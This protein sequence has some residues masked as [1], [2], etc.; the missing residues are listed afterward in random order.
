MRP[1]PREARTQAGRRPARPS[2][3]ARISS[4]S[5]AN[6]GCAA[7]RRR[8]TR[9]GRRGRRRRCRAA[10]RRRRHAAARGQI[11]RAPLQE[12]AQR[13][14]RDQTAIEQRRDAGAQP[15][16]AELREH[17]RDVVVV[18]RDARGRCAAPDRATRR[19]A[20]AP[21]CRRRGRSRDRRRPRAETRAAATGR[22]R[23]SSRSRCRRDAPSRSRQRAASNSREPARLPQP[24]DDPL[25]HLRRGLARERDREDVVGLDAGAQQVDVA[26]DEHAR[27]AGAGRRFEHDVLR[28]IDARMRGRRV[29]QQRCGSSRTESRIATCGRPSC[30]RSSSSNGSVGS[31]VADVVLPAHGR[32][33]ARLAPPHI[34]GRRREL[35]ALDRV[36]GVGEPLL[37][38]GQHLGAVGARRRTA[39]RR[40]SGP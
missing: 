22:T 40:A 3:T 11:A 28:R 15:P 6:C 36:D 19:P 23:R 31:D 17:Q 18:A 4:A 38:L 34:V 33:A 12:P 35:A 21:R 32:E 24:L 10:A 5:I 14:R 30:I 20:A 26:L 8:E 29:G 25:P 1:A 27:L 39:A 16:L 2:A 13:L 7:G 37:R 9:R